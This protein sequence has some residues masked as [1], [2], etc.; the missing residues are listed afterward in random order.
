MTDENQIIIEHFQLI[1]GIAKGF[2]YRDREDYIQV[3][4]IG[5]LKAIRSFNPTKSK[6]TTHATNC[7][8]N[9]MIRE[10]NKHQKYYVRNVNIPL[11][12]IPMKPEP[13]PLELQ[14]LT[15]DE[16]LIVHMR[17][18]NESY[19]AIASQLGCSRNKIRRMLN[20]IGKKI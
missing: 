13:P 9:E 4:R 15:Q 14:M 2:P 10:Y 7:V 16:R 8:R 1:N 20:T 19:K 18:N 12:H 11:D 3:G 5:V 17:L 6:F